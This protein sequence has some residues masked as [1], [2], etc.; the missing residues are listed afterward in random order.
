[1]LDMRRQ[2]AV[3]CGKRILNLQGHRIWS[4]H[5]AVTKV[6]SE[7]LDIIRGG[8]RTIYDYYVDLGRSTRPTA[9]AH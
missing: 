4:L 5:T 6:V 9:G 8:L 3:G 7:A 1:M 2:S